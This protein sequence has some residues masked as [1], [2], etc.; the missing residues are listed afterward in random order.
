MGKTNERIQFKTLKT[1][2]REINTILI[3]LQIKVYG[4]CRLLKLSIKTIA[5][6]RVLFI[7]ELCM[8]CIL[9]HSRCW[10]THI[11]AINIHT[12]CVMVDAFS[13]PLRCCYNCY[14]AFGFDTDIL[15]EYSSS[16]V[17]VQLFFFNS[18]TILFR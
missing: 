11:H 18:C 10:H 1:R 5:C 16:V 8:I 2:A 4:E 17:V 7:C 14:F 3:I 13:V 12:R 15:V 6:S 9:Q